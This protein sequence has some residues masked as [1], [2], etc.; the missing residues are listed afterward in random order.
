MQLFSSWSKAELRVIIK[1]F[2]NLKDT[3]P[4]FYEEFRIVIG[5]YDLGLP[6]LFQFIH[7]TLGLGNT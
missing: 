3:P 6:D 5:A 1:D 4:K 7:M 2:P